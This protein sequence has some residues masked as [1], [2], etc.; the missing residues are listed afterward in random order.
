MIKKF[1]RSFLLILAA[2]LTLVSLSLGQMGTM[3]AKPAPD[4]VLKDIAGKDFK[5][6]RQTLGKIVIIDFWA[7]WCPPCIK[8]VP[9]LQKLY[10]RYKNRGLVIVGISMDEGGVNDVVPF[11]N[12]HRVTYPVVLGNEKV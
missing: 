11:L 12:K 8:E 9:V 10:A 3:V 5:L 1:L 6:S 7:S 2:S 4:F